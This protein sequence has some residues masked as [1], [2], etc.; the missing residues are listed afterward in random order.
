[1]LCGYAH[2]AEKFGLHTVTLIQPAQ[3]SSSVSK[4]I[5]TQG[6]ILVPVRMAPLEDDVFGHLSFAIK[7]EGT[8]LEILSQALPKIEAAVLQ[9]AVDAAPSS[10]IARK[11]AWL[12]EEFTA[13]RLRYDRP[14][15]AYSRLFDP[16]LY[17]T[18]PEVQIPRWRVIYNGLGPI[19]YCP[20]VRRVPGLSEEEIDKTFERLH[21][22]MAS[23]SPTLLKRAVDWAYL[24]ET[25]SSFAI[26]KEP[27]SGSKAQRFMQLLKNV[28]LFEHLDEDKLCEIQNRIVSSP[29]SQA[30]TY[31]SEQNWLSNS[32]AFGVRRVAYLPPPPEM[33]EDLMHGWLELANT[34]GTQ[35]NPL[36]AAS[37]ASFGFVYLHPFLDGNGRLSRFLVHHQLHKARALPEKHVLPVSAAMLKHEHAYLDALEVFSA[38]SRDLWDVLQIDRDDYEFTFKATSAVYRYWDATKQTEF[39]FA[40]IREAINTFLPEEI[41]FLQKYDRVYRAMNERFDVVQKDLDMLVAAGISAG[42]ISQNLKKKYKYRVP[43]GFFEALESELSAEQKGR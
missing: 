5:R 18:G 19:S 35:I 10:A 38:P 7:H 13:R 11:L 39:L 20:V 41:N 14:A 43:E 26:E 1:M 21:K 34:K 9:A 16:K 37:A 29:F 15:G 27:P 2:L 42:R 23:I 8:N 24:S 32:G 40:M 30:M 33:L 4:L 22:Q 36:I 12:W 31:R 6:Q 28:E 3:A 17:F 25:R